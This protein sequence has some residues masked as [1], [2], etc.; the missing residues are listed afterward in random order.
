MIM[1]FLLAVYTKQAVD[2]GLIP[3]AQHTAYGSDNKYHDIQ[4]NCPIKDGSIKINILCSSCNRV[5]STQKL[6]FIVYFENGA[7]LRTE[8]ENVLVH[9]NANMEDFVPERYIM[10][11]ADTNVLTFYADSKNMI[12][13]SYEDVT[14]RCPTHNPTLQHS[15]TG[16][17][18]Y[19][20]SSCP[21]IE[22]SIKTYVTCRVCNMINDP[23][24]KLWAKF[25]F[26][27]GEYIGVEHE[28]VI[29]HSNVHMERFV[30]PERINYDASTYTLHYYV[31]ST[32]MDFSEFGESTLICLGPVP[33]QSP[34]ATPTASQSPT[35][36]KSPSV[37]PEIIEYKTYNMTSDGRYS[38]EDDDTQRVLVSMI[39]VN[40]T[41]VNSPLEGGAIYI[42]NIGY[43]SDGCV[44]DSCSSQSAG[45]AVYLIYTYDID[46]FFTLIN[47]QFKGNEAK[48]GGAVYVYS[49]SKKNVVKIHYC[50]FEGNTASE[51]YKADNLYGGSSA[52]VIARTITV[53][54]NKFRN[55]NG[56]G[57][58]R[59]VNNFKTPAT[60]SLF[61][62][63]N[64]K[65]LIADC[66][67]EV[68]SKST[69]ALYF[70][71]GNYGASYELRKCSFSGEL[72]PGCHFIDGQSVSKNSAK[73]IV[74]KCRFST[75]YKRA[76]NLNN[77][78]YLSVDLNDQ[79]F[80]AFGSDLT[81]EKSAN[82]WKII[83]AVAVPAVVIAV[84]ATV[85]VIKRRTRND[86]KEEKETEIHNNLIN[87][88]LL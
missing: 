64:D 52:Y 66:Q 83:V 63:N 48:Y 60:G 85:I 61:F 53:L 28:D 54:N 12:Y 49:H 42:K 43:Q 25:N 5:T 80:D 2:Y 77:N 21:I 69:C 24:R 38:M 78:D 71:G 22:G 57:D 20:I 29:V 67:F 79:V 6:W 35:A 68:G 18:Y 46:N 32:N 55:N 33:T 44:F 1:L 76:L 30:P 23:T 15:N 56:E 62:L 74:K 31:D 16:K 70:Y 8:R 84:I 39:N 19:M 41:G 51:G 10:F 81:V 3:E 86:A 65:L 27:N 87:E 47:H 7:Y 58:F 13:D 73:L 72:A 17:D 14:L 40:F 26:E 59:I 34:M 4:F 75:D 37:S 9:N 11:N 50:S 82:L 88:E 45:G 36:S